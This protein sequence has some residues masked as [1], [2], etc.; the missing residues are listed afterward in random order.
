LNN[1]PATET[2][3]Q[4]RAGKKFCLLKV[5]DDYQNR[6]TLMVN[7]V[8]NLIDAEAGHYEWPFKLGE[9]VW[10]KTHG[11][12]AR[13]VGGWLELSPFGRRQEQVPESGD[14]SQVQVFYRVETTDGREF[15]EPAQALERP[16]SDASM[17][18]DA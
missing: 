10:S 9:W 12:A 1:L 4:G 14:T 2:E 3:R 11:F 15:T 13:V 18:V 8:V 7:R 5:T 16:P 17:K 6:R